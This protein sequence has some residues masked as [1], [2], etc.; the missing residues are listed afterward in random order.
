MSAA[1]NHLVDKLKAIADKIDPQ[2]DGIAVL[3]VGDMQY[4]FGRP[5]SGNAW[6]DAVQLVAA[7]EEAVGASTSVGS[8]SGL[9]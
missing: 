2:A 7:L 4:Q 1:T 6:L 8:T 5:T 9:E 3:I